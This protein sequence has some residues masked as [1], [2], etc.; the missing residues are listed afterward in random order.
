M[1]S[2]E[3]VAR[4]IRDAVFEVV[5][6][7]N[8]RGQLYDGPAVPGKRH[9]TAQFSHG[10]L[11]L[12]KGGYVTFPHDSRFDLA[13]P[14]SIECWARLDQP[15]Q[16]PVLLSCGQWN[17]AGWF[18]QR[19]GNKWRWHV[20]GIDC[21]GGHTARLYEDGKL[22][23]QRVGRSNQT[24]WS[25]ELHLGQYSAQPGPSYQMTGRLKG[26]RIYHRPL[27]ASELAPMKR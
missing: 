14:L 15:G 1:A 10:E 19:L 13:Q 4:V 3:A 20:G 18:L 26:V 6:D 12:R 24:Q 27:D 25:G 2:I 9:G 7:T 22:V 5:F 11:D 17:Q 8:A 16:M 21:D 23:G